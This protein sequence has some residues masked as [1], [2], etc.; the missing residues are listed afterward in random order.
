MND[1]INKLIDHYQKALLIKPNSIVIHTKLADLYYQQGDLE[2]VLNSCWEVLQHQQ[3]LTLAPKILDRL[4]KDLGF[5]REEAAAFQEILKDTSTYIESYITLEKIL[6]LSESVKQVADAETW[7]DAIALGYS[8]RQQNLWDEAMQAYFKA[9]EI[10]PSLIF[11]HFMLQYLVLPHISDLELVISWYDQTIQIPRI[12][13]YSCFVL[14][15][16]LTKQGQFQEAIAYYK[17]AWLKSNIGN[18]S[19]S[20]GEQQ[21]TKIDYLI[22]GVGKSGTSSLHQYLSQ[23]PQVINPYEKELHFF[24]ENFEAGI[25]W[26]L[27]QFPPLSYKKRHFLTGEATPWYLASHEAE[28]RVFQLFPKIKL[29]AVLRNPVA[30]AISH[31]QMNLRMGQEQRSLEEA[32]TSEM[33]VLCELK[34]IEEAAEIYWKTEKGYLWFGLY[35]YFIQKWMALFPSNQLLILKNEDLYNAPAV[36]M[37]QVFSFLELSDYELSSY[38]K[39]NSGSY[40]RNSDDL[41]QALSDFFQ[42]HNQRLEE[43]LGRDFNWK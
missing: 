4:L 27:A 34:N 24:S 43:Y 7:K 19:E 40:P 2:Q 25:D 32:M 1:R 6:T 30:R 16:L 21:R 9:I 22:I 36:T 23:H 15:H 17:K 3:K 8:L 11:P 5:E 39:W 37:K 26:Y 31:Y 20:L 41:H 14:G 35:F 18:F 38:P 29:I 42:P 10:Q 28:K 12:C 13:P 33:A